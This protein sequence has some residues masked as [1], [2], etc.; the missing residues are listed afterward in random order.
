ML[1][2][3]TV[4]G[5]KDWR[6]KLL[7]KLWHGDLESETREEGLLPG[8]ESWYEGLNFGWRVQGGWKIPLDILLM[9]FQGVGKL[10]DINRHGCGW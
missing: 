3:R 5:Y 10:G 2:D 9:D 6:L 7:Q 1:I 4:T 8:W